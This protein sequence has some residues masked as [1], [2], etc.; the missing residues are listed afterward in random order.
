MK[1]GSATWTNSETTVNLLL[2]LLHR[3]R[4]LTILKTEDAIPNENLILIAKALVA[5]DG[6]A[7]H[8]SC[9]GR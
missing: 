4:I 5:V 9:V 8:S 1:S 6:L 7:V 3:T 2:A